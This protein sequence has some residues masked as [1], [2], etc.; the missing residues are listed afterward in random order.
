MGD[1]NGA[2]LSTLGP[3]LTAQQLPVSPVR[4]AGRSHAAPT[5]QRP[6]GEEPFVHA[7]PIVGRSRTAE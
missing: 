1:D 7:K 2:G 6:M 4:R 5:S 3:G